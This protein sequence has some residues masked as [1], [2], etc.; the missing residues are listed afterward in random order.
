MALIKIVSYNCRGLPRN[1]DALYS[2]PSVQLL[3]ANC[4]VDIA[5]LQETWYTKQ[6]LGNLHTLHAAFHGTGAATIDCRDALFHGHPPG[7]VSFLWRTKYDKHITPLEFEVDWLTGIRFTN[8]RSYV[9]LCIYM[10]YECR[11]NDDMYM[12]NLGV[13]QSILDEIDVTCMSIIGDWNADIGDSRSTFAAHLKQFCIDTGLV[14]SSAN[15]LPSGTFT[16]LSESWNTTTWLDFCLS[17]I[18]GNSCIQ[19]MAQSTLSVPIQMSV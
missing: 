12:E 14:I 2:R 3:L 4:D 10:P 9:V 16:H 7:G 13:L 17:S 19:D 1:S 5:C 18:D 8:G 11:L 6:D 15:V